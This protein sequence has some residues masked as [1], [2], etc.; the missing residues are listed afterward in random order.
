MKGKSATVVLRNGKGRNKAAL[1]G[2]LVAGHV[3]VYRRLAKGANGRFLD[4]FLRSK[5]RSFFEQAKGAEA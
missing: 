4:T 2:R 1:G 5:E 3:V